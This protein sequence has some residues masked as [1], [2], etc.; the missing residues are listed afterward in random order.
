VERALILAEKDF[1]DFPDL[2]PEIGHSNV[3]PE[4]PRPTDSLAQR[5]K[6][7]EVSERKIVEEALTS[8]KGNVTEAARLLGITRIMMRYRIERFGLR[9]KDT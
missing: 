1:I 6:E 5:F 2:S 7:L 4:E 9:V 3:A 8:A